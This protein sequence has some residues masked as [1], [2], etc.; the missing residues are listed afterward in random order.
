MLNEIM[1]VKLNYIISFSKDMKWHRILMVGENGRLGVLMD[2]VKTSLTK[3]NYYSMSSCQFKYFRISS[4]MVINAKND[5][6]SNQ[7]RRLSLEL[8]SAMLCSLFCAA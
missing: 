2:Y 6:S 3:E 1:Y 8:S 4:V 5:N 7:S